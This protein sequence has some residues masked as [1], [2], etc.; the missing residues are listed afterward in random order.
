[1]LYSGLN[2]ILLCWALYHRITD[3]IRS[4]DLILV[5]DVKKISESSG[6]RREVFKRGVLADTSMGVVGTRAARSLR[7][8]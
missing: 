7:L 1:M 4:F 5:N 6:E 2:G 8:I 3:L